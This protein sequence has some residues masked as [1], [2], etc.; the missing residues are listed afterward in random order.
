M[1][2]ER[3]YNIG[4]IGLGRIGS[5]YLETLAAA[6]RWNV[7]SVCDLDDE[8]LAAAKKLMPDTDTTK[9][10]EVAINH[11]YIEVVGIFTLADARPR[12]I[13]RSLDRGKH[14]IAEKPIADSVAVE[15]ELLR[16]IE[17]TDRVVAVNLFNRN[18]WYHEQLQAFI[19]QGEIG[20]LAIISVSHQTRRAYA[21]GRTPARRSSIS[22]LWNA[23]RRCRSMVR[24][25][26]VRLV[27]R[28]GDPNV[29]LERSVVGQRPRSI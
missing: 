8:R 21:D 17:A 26:R 28:S 4:I 10:S 19:D 14:V 25:Q 11:P 20:E 9:D 1:P 13:E 16:K 24:S 27:A 6:A 2:A 7:V 12:L 3:R 5:R 15:K 23:L 18:A 22:R 29:E